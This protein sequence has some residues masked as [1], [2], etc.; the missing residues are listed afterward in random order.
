MVGILP[1]GRGT[2][3]VFW[4]VRADS[5]DAWRA[6]GL[7]AWKQEVSALMPEVP[8]EA[9]RHADDVIFAPYF[10]VV[11][12][13]WHHGRVAWLGDAGHA[14]SPQLGQGANLA[15]QDAAALADAPDL[16]SYSAARRAQLRF[17]SFA[18][19]ML[20][21]FFQSSW[22]VLAPA[23][24]LV[25][26]PLHAWGWYRHQM[27]ASLAGVKTGLFSELPLPE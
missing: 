19:R 2:V 4:S 10:D 18:S 5:L 3:S 9:V 25:A 23:R 26:G 22:P 27:L 6:A 7:D 17:Y 16:A 15:L 14:M 8:V 12:P 1:S 13:A 24:D 20:T 11:A 21:P